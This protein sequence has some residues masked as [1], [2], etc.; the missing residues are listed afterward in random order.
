[1]EVP[2]VVAETELNVAGFVDQI[3]LSIDVGPTGPR[4]SLIFSGV[5]EPPTVPPISDPLF[6]NVDQFQSNDFYIRLGSPG[7]AWLYKYEDAPGGAVWTPVV[8]MNPPLYA[9]RNSIVFTSGVGAV[10]TIPLT[11]I[12]GTSSTT[13]TEDKF[14][15]TATAHYTTNDTNVYAIDVKGVTVSAPNLLVY[16]NMRQITSSAVS[17][18]SATLSVNTIIGVSP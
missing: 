6:N 8:S 17:A 11:E 14:V 12:I 13:L 18:P 5:G 15:V 10:L 1:M 2:I 4:G 16:L 7:Y 9:K 3:D